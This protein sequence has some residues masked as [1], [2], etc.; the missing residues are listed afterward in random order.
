MQIYYPNGS[1]DSK[2]VANKIGKDMAEYD[3]DGKVAIK[4]DKETRHRSN[5]LLQ[6]KNN[7]KEIPSILIELGFQSNPEDLEQL[8]SEKFRKDSMDQLAEAITEYMTEGEMTIFDY[9]VQGI[10]NGS[11]KY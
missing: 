1:D 6:A 3:A 11:M 5:G 4:S 10:Q 2:N 8:L 9:F 7:E